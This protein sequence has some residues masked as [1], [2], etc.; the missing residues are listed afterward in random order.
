MLR[1]FSLYDLFVLCFVQLVVSTV[2]VLSPARMIGTRFRWTGSR[3][4]EVLIGAVIAAALAAF[5]CFLTA[6]LWGLPAGGVETAAYVLAIFSVIVIVLRPD[7]GVIGQRLLRLI[8]RGRDSLSSPSRRSWRRWRDAFDRRGADLVLPDPARP[9][10]VLGLE[11][12]HQLRE[13]RLV[14]HPPLASD[15]RRPIPPTSRWC[16]CTSRPTTSPLRS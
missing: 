8:R 10:G 12:E 4:T 2:L 5:S 9:G 14:P 15:P 7:C 11:L 16:P 6:E 13:R 3:V 1:E